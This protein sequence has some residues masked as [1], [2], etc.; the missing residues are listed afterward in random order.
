MEA[1]R[2]TPT[3][4]EEFAGRDGDSVKILERRLQMEVRLEETIIQ[5]ILGL[6]PF[7]LADVANNVGRALVLPRE[8]T[9]FSQER[10]QAAL[11]VVISELDEVSQVVLLAELKSYAGW[12]PKIQ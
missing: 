10:A 7:E 8:L 3:I 5:A 4:R 11:R 1:D 2:R 6:S 9:R 12:K